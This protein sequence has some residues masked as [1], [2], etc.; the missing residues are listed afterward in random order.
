[1][2]LVVPHNRPPTIFE[3][4]GCFSGFTAL[5]EIEKVIRSSTKKVQNARLK[6]V[7]FVSILFSSVEVISI[8]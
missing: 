4:T 1:M 6:G 3:K 2:S 8:I 5:H 7:L